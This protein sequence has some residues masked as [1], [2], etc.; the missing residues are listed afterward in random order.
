MR[1]K[2]K[3]LPTFKSKLYK[4]P[5]VLAVAAALGTLPVHAAVKPGD[6][7]WESAVTDST[8]ASNIVVYIYNTEVAADADGDSLVAMELSKY[9]YA[10]SVDVEAGIYYRRFNADGSAEGELKQIKDFLSSGDDIHTDDI[11]LSQNADN[12]AVILWLEHNDTA[13]THKLFAQP[14]AANGTLIGAPVEIS[15]LNTEYQM[16]MD[17]DGNFIVAW[18]EYPAATGDDI[19]FRR[20]KADGT[21]LDAAPVIANTYTTDDQQDP[22]LAVASNGDF[23][24][25]WES[26]GQDGDDDGVYA[27]RFAADG[28]PKDSIEFQV[29]QDVADDQESPQITMDA[30]GGFMIAWENEAGGPPE[31]YNRFFAAD[32]SPKGDEKRIIQNA[33]LDDAV[34]DADGDFI[35]ISEGYAKYQ[36]SAYFFKADE[37]SAVAQTEF[38]CIGGVCDLAVD[39]DGD[40]IVT[41]GSAIDNPAAAYDTYLFQISRYQGVEETDL[42]ATIQAS[43]ESIETGGTVEFT[44]NVSNN[45]TVA[46]TTG[47]AAVDQAIGAALGVTATF[48]LPGAGSLISA[49]G[50][51]WTCDA[52]TSGTLTC[53][54]GTAL[55]AGT[56]SNVVIQWQAP[57]T[58][59]VLAISMSDET[60][61][62]DPDMLN[63]GSVTAVS[64][65]KPDAPVAVQG[66]GGGGTMGWFSLLLLPLFGL[67]RFQRKSNL[68]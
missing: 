17:A 12:D 15:T 58:E 13:S 20:F 6:K 5:L 21:E 8:P 67:K 59:A 51:G 42:A 61:V 65:Q 53:E 28:T 52:V 40:A 9:D 64:V 35:I 37:S 16:D 48:V 30:K 62:N 27:R 56:N 45:H 4:K 29:H 50:T 54:L 49:S 39:A 33:E 14:M 34:M 32:G 24:L 68:L 43:A 19:Y 3:S 55:L 44:G 23:I 26:D 22:D 36:S 60:P 38:S 57:D 41:E 1:T 47:V 10:T 25:T 18:T 11:L 7:T 31:V 63:N 66:S 2:N 46:G